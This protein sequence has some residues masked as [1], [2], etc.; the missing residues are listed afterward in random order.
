MLQPARAAV[1]RKAGTNS[2]AATRN[3]GWPAN[4]RRDRR[5]NPYRL[6]KLCV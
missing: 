3:I 5:A 2:L 4:R 1:R 6:C